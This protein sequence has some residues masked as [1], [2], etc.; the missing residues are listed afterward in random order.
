MAK[1][2][3]ANGVAANRGLCVHK[4]LEC[5]LRPDRRDYVDRM[6]KEKQALCVPS[7]AR[8][9]M[10]LAKKLKVDAADHVEKIKTFILTAVSFDFY[11]EGCID[12]KSEEWF[13]IEKNGYII[14]GKIDVTAVFDDK[15]VCRDFKTSRAKYNK[16]DI[17]FPIQALMYNL[18]LKEKYPN[19]PIEVD[20]V[21]LKYVKKPFQKTKITEQLLAGFES[22]LEYMAEYLEDF[23]YEKGVSN[24][25]AHDPSRKF[26][27]GKEMGSLDKENNEAF[28]C[29]FRYPFLY[30]VLLDGE[31][32]IKKSRNREELE[33]IRRDG[34]T[35]EMREQSGCPAWKHNW[36]NK[37][38]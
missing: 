5:L 10:Y 13:S 33:Y 8:L 21:F 22:W 29:G 20:F 18:A 25:A 3:E 27:C 14:N 32:I 17:D 38:Q 2:P 24:F 11:C 1:L 9:T 19:L 15:I 35:L 12:L 34:M 37:E 4:V 23:D 6:V 16:E 31:K 30:W 36:E 28:V 7:V 26:L